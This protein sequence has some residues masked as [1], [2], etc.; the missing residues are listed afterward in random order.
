MA[1]DLTHQPCYNVQR[2]CMGC[3]WSF[4]GRK[5]RKYCSQ[6][7]ATRSGNLSRGCQDPRIPKSVMSPSVVQ[8]AWA[9]GLYEGEGSVHGANGHQVSLMQ[10]DTWILR[11]LQEFFGG[12]LR[13]K[14]NGPGKSISA[15][16]LSGARARGFLM[17][18]Y[19]FLSPRRQEQAMRALRRD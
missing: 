2:V 9:A 1:N 5:R 13:L 10:K 19:K 15:W 6:P 8:I 12:T 4:L 3:G 11:R 7:C 14:L 16:T 18:I 17:T